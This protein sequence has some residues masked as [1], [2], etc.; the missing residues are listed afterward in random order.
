M[1]DNYL[2]WRSNTN[3]RPLILPNRD[4]LYNELTNIE[5]SW[6][7]RTDVLKLSNTFIMEALQLLIRE[8]LRKEVLSL[9]LL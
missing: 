9:V 8:R 7:G 6:S 5:H 2:K 3:L 1:A 4:K